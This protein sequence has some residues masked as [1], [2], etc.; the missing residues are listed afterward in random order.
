MNAIRDDF[1]LGRF[2]DT[3]R[4]QA[5]RAGLDETEC[6]FSLQADLGR[7]ARA[8][9]SWLVV[10]RTQIAAF[11]VGR[12]AAETTSGAHKDHVSTFDKSFRH[13]LTK[14]LRAG[15]WSRLALNRPTV[16]LTVL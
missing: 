4:E 13:R 12:P 5:C 9:E 10:T 8:C 14:R 2:A 6:L 3:I 16:L 7:D 1:I 11:A 15:T